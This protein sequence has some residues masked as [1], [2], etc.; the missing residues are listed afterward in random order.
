MIVNLAEVTVPFF[1]SIPSVTSR[2]V[3]RANI[4]RRREQVKSL[5]VG[6]SVQN[7]DENAGFGRPLW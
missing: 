4:A 6:G 5:E 7:R 1:P 2:N 3:L